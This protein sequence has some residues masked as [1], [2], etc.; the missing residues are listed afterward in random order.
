MLQP[1]TAPG[2]TVY[3]TEVAVNE[4]LKLTS[5]RS[6]CVITIDLVAQ[7]SILYS[8]VPL[9]RKLAESYPEALAASELG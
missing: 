6:D 3:G 8:G 9:Y 5:I 1:E 2:R 7:P 4:R